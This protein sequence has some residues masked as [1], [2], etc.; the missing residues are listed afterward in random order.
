M[1]RLIE[2]LI[3]APIL[4]TTAIATEPPKPEMC[5]FSWPTDCGRA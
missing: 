3:I 1:R 4:A 5:C 2:S